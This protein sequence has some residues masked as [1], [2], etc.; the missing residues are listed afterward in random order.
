MLLLITHPHY[1]MSPLELTELRKRLSKLVE[2]GLIQPSKAPY[3][4]P[5]L[6]QKKQD[7]SLRMCV[8]YS[9]LNKVIVKNK[10]LVPLVQDLMD[11]LS[12][13]NFFLS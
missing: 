6:F 2:A 7:G 5:I 1:R 13:V 4:A 12:K 10:Y 8:D 3:G 9:A 11:R